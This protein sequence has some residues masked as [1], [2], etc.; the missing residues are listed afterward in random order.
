MIVACSTGKDST[1]QQGKAGAYA[2]GNYPNW[3]KQPYEDGYFDPHYDG[4]L[5]LFS[6][7]HLSGN[8]QIIK[9]LSITS[10]FIIQTNK[11]I[12]A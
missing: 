1:G 10:S 8:Y 4:L 11:T 2:S 12:A 9:S 6:L 3:F 7:L 5:Y